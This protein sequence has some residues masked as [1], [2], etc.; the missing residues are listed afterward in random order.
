MVESIGSSRLKVYYDVANNAWLGIDPAAEIRELGSRIIASILKI[1]PAYVE[2]PDLQQI[3]L[4][5]LE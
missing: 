5:V 1:A 4:E 3:R 2:L